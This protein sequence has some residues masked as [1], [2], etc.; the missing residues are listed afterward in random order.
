MDLFD[1]ADWLKDTSNEIKKGIE[2]EAHKDGKKI[3]QACKAKCPFD[4]G[5]LRESITTD[6]ERRGNLVIAKVGTNKEYAPY[7]NYGTGIYTAGGRQGGWVYTPD[8]EH[9]YFTMGQRPTYFMEEGLT[10]AI[11]EISQDIDDF[12][13]R[14]FK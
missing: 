5:K 1:L 9:Y 13:R 8:G 7:V 6:V 10:L 4:T 11:P 3:E 12:I 2:E 14:L